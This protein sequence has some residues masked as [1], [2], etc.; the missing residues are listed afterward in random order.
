MNPCDPGITIREYALA[1]I[2]KRVRTAAKAIERVAESPDEE[3]VHKM[4]V[5]IRR[6]QQAI[7]VFRQYL[8]KRGVKRVRADL[9]RLMDPAGEL[10]NL[11][12][13][14]GT[15]R[16]AGCRLGEMKER[17]IVAKHALT[18]A[19]TTLAGR[20]VARR[21]SGQLGIEMHEEEALEV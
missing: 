9:K 16:R 14:L 4:R 2:A 18:A 8:R 5:S 21:W 6:L 12:I 13:A 20:H 19:I 7:R 17:R 10:R 1:T 15:M 11:D 3:A